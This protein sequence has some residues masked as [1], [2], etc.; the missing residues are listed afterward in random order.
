[1]MPVIGFWLYRREENIA[2]R[3]GSLSEY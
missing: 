1:L 2:R 3:K